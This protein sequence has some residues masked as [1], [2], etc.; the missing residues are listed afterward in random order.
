MAG[1]HREVYCSSERIFTDSL[2]Q[3]YEIERRD[4]PINV[5]KQREIKIYQAFYRTVL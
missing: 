4:Q 5:H 3:R 2:C 1:Q